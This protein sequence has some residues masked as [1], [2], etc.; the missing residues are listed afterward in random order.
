MT[1]RRGPIYS[2]L[3]WSIS[4]MA[5]ASKRTPLYANS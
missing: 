3:D 1:V 2:I 4:G 5:S